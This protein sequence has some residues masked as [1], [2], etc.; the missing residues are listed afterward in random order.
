MKLTGAGLLGV[1]GG[2]LII[3]GVLGGLTLSK[4]NQLDATHDY[5]ARQDLKQGGE[6]LAIATDVLIIGGAVLAL[7]GVAL[8]AVGI[9]KG[10]SS[11]VAQRRVLPTG[12]GLVA[13]F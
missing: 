8:L 6:R 7:T 12:T 11:A 2:A 13:R 1:G 3:G 5:A 10:K 9:S 4:Q